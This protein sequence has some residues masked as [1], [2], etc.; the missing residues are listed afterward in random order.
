M[1]KKQPIYVENV[2]IIDAGSEG[3]AVA[4]IN[5]K[6]VFIPYA[7]PGDVVNIRIIKE[8]KSF[9]EGKIESFVKH[10]KQRVEPVCSH[11]GVCGGCKW[12]HLNYESQL[13]YK[14]KQVVDHFKR[15]GKLENINPETSSGQ[16][17]E[18]IIKADNEIYY[19]NKLEYTFTD[20]AWLTKAVETPNLGV[21]NQLKARGHAHLPKKSKD[22]Q[23]VETPNL[24]VSTALGFHVPG[25]FD[26]VVNI[27]HC[28]LQAEPSNKIR[29]FIKEF[30]DKNKMSFFN[31]RNQHGL[32]RNLVIRISS[33]GEIMLILILV[34]VINCVFKKYII[35]LQK[36]HYDSNKF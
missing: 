28:Y 24:G 16:V 34:K 20:R 3:K 35:S 31:I 18:P 30:A 33:T 17:I 10:S 13:F 9:V 23:P 25:F 8:K 11:Y 1:R 29:L 12:Q 6:I 14:Q 36:K 15:I 4:K 22:A 26:K 27:N 32:L 7:A 19:R 21:S 5:D 2:E